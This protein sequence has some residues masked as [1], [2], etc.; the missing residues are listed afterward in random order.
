MRGSSGVSVSG[1]GGPGHHLHR[2][3]GRYQ[4]GDGRHFRL[5]PGPC[6]PFSAPT[7]TVDADSAHAEISAFFPVVNNGIP[8]V[9]GLLAPVS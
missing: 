8:L 4:S 1:I 5:A 2:I 6:P 7:Y 3:A 9:S